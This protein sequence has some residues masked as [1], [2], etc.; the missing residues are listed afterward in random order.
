M[1]QDSKN[2]RKPLILITNDDGIRAKGLKALAKVARE[3]GRVVVMAPQESRSGMSHA[4]T[5]EHPLRV[6]EQKSEPGYREY[7]CTGTPVDCVKLALNRLLE[8]KPDLVLSGVNHGSN[9]SISV[10]YSGTMAAAIEGCI[11]KI[12]S[13]GFSLL[14]YDQ[15]ADFTVAEKYVRILIDRVLKNGLPAGIC[16]NVNIPALPEDSVKGV[17]IC[18]Q[19]DGIWQEEFVRRTDPFERDY[20]WLTGFFRNFES[21]AEDTDEWALQHGYVSVVPIKTDLT[22]YDLINTLKQWDYED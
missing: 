22:D 3:F 21:E 2:E 5:S 13:V 17:K 14:D 4:I 9:D 8:E 15:D 18:R 20:Y 11:N 10:F 19:T 12:P 1:K 7:A 16:L 6:Y